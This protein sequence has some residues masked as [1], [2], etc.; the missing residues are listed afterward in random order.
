M[1]EIAE[2]YMGIF[3]Q[4]A[5]ELLETVTS[6]LLELEKKPEDREIVNEIFRA[7]HTLKGSSGMMGFT[8]LQE[9]AHKMEDI[10]DNIRKGLMVPSPNLIDVLFECV[11]AIEK[12]IIRLEKGEREEEDFSGLIK[13]IENCLN[14]NNIVGGEKTF[15]LPSIEELKTLVDDDSL[16]KCFIITVKLSDDCVFKSARAYMVVAALKKFGKILKH[17]PKIEEIENSSFNESSFTLLFISDH[18]KE[19]IE[20]T[21][22]N[23]PEIGEVEV[24]PLRNICREKT[25]TEPPNKS[26]RKEASSKSKFKTDF[27]QVRTV[28]VRRE[29][30]DKLMNLVGELIV[31]KIQLLKASSEYKLDF[32]KTTVDNIDR[33]TSEL[34]DLVMR[35]RMVPIEHIFNRFPR[36]VRDISRK[37]GKKVNFII[38]GKEIEV[39]RTVLEEIGEPI[40]HLLRNAVDHG[41]EPPE[42]RKKMGKSPEGTVRLVAERKRDHILIIV[43]DDGAG[44]DP[45]KVKKKAIE[46][47]LINEKEANAMTAQQLID[48]IFLPGFSTAEKITETSGRGVGMDVVKT[49]IESLGGSVNIET[50]VGKGTKVTLTLPLTLAIVKAMLIEAADQTYAIPL[51]LINEVIA[52]RKIEVKKIGNLQAIKLRDKVLPIFHL[53]KLLGYPEYKKEKYDALI[54]NKGSAYFGLIVDSILGM[55]EIVIK[56]L[57][58]SLKKIR[59]IAGVTILGN[60]KVVLIL[61]P[62]ALIKE[63]LAQHSHNFFKTC[64][65]RNIHGKLIA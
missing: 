36:L 38:E 20:K 30:L 4:E 15:S 51:S 13:K 18:D 21:I 12:R 3:I 62:I 23:I 27:S 31:N 59:G 24:K 10:F 25:P 50:A 32:L 56:T 1:S 22:K 57:D 26:Q 48:L 45:E 49:K 16:E 7:A 46:K 14:G 5:K 2:Q 58:E 52:I 35:I 29:D 41:I 55:Q 28:K 33:L 9:L 43:E 64:I 17:S 53:R 37:A 63:E 39:D 40:L 61:D 44:I 11:D 54:I 60:G 19:E 47:G 8:D 6:S 65:N 34:Q 42:Q